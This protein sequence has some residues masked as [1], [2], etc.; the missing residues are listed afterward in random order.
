MK[1]NKTTSEIQRDAP[2]RRDA[3]WC[4]QPSTGSP[5]RYEGSVECRAVSLGSSAGGSRKRGIVHRLGVLR[6]G[7]DRVFGQNSVLLF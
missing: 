7:T 2:H 3:E 5:Q 4:V 1:S 6:C